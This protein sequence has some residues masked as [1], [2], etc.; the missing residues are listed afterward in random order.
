MVSVLEPLEKYQNDQPF[1]LWLNDFDD[2]V[3]ANFGTVSNDRVRP[4]FKVFEA[5]P[6]ADR[7]Q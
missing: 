7:S 4:F 3:L 5:Q 1:E 6:C 2:F